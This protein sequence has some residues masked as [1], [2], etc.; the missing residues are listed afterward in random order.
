MKSCN[1]RRSNETP[2]EGRG[3]AAGDPRAL[4]LSAV[5]GFGRG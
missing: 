3:R 2:F 1:R 5:E 4:V